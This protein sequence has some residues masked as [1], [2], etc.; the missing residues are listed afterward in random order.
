LVQVEGKKNGRESEGMTGK[1]RCWRGGAVCCKGE[2][3][4]HVRGEQ[5]RVV[6]FG[7]V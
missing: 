3:R 7:G 2:K 1:P 5:Q 6:A 4:T